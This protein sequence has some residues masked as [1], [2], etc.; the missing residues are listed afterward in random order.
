[1]SVEAKEWLRR[2]QN[3]ITQASKKAAGFSSGKKHIIAQALVLLLRFGQVVATGI[4][5]LIYFYFVYEQ[6]THYCHYYPTSYRCNTR[7]KL[8]DLPLSYVFILTSVS[9]QSS[10]QINALLLIRTR[11]IDNSIIRSTLSRDFPQTP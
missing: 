1:M 11:P 2:S 9:T 8:Y 7:S 4:L 6:Q 10:N 5:A 3:A